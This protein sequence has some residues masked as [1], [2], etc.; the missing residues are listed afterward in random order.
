MA[1]A[2][3]A[4]NNS[5][6]LTIEGFQ[7]RFPDGRGL[8][9]SADL[10]LFPG[11]C[12]LVTG[13]TGSGKT[14]LL[15]AIA[16]LLPG[17]TEGI[18]RDPQDSV[19]LAFQNP[20]TQLFFSDV[21]EELGFAPRNRGLPEPAVKSRISTYLDAV[22]L[23]GWESRSIDGL[24]MG[25]KHR[26]AMAAACSAEPVLLLLDEPFA[27]LD[28]E[29]AVSLRR[30]LRNYLQAGG[31]VVISEHHPDLVAGIAC[32]SLDLPTVDMP[33]LA[34]SIQRDP[35]ASP[36]IPRTD[37]DIRGLRLAAPDSGPWLLRD[38]SWQVAGG[39]RIHI[40]GPNGSGK[41]SLLRALVGL[42]EVES[43]NV[44]VAGQA[45]SPAALAGRVA[46]LH[47]DPDSQ[48]SA[49]SV[50]EEVSFAWERLP[51]DRR[52][53]AGW[54]DC[55]L[56]SLGLAALAQRS[57]LSLSFG[58]KHLV[59]LAAALACRPR[60][61]LLDEPFT[62]LDQGRVGALCDFLLEYSRAYESTL[63]M[64]SHNALPEAGWATRQFVMED[65]RFLEELQR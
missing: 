33:P 31:T 44:E 1:E 51:A 57:P 41:S 42:Q 52:P 12:A 36:T 62:G 59:T 3:E 20:G 9:L 38:F 56:H 65:G 43:G 61:V 18:Y 55:L 50:R 10:R 64:A 49:P 8:T 37:I 63:V 19:G 15:Y 7:H 39:E 30:L 22:G 23:P 17:H 32:C 11:E 5:P 58:E 27:Q 45:P 34:P 48:L 24:S 26:V 40:R 21:G 54:I 28:A 35:S 47:Q 4:L 6:S 60:L 25:E 16:G 2:R 46:F 53:R 29:G 14:S 13:A